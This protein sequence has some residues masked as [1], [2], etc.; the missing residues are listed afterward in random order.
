ATAR[1]DRTP[2][3]GSGRRT[4]PAPPAPGP[5]RARATRDRAPGCRLEAPRPG[6]AG[7]SLSPLRTN[8]AG[9]MGK[10]DRALSAPGP[11]SKPRSMH[12]PRG[13]CESD[14]ERAL[15]GLAQSRVG[16][17]GRVH[18]GRDRQADPERGALAGPAVHAHV[19]AVQLGDA[20]HEMEPDPQAAARLA[21]LGHDL[22]EQLEDV[23]GGVG[24]D[25]GTLVVDLDAHAG[26]VLLRAQAYGRTARAELDRVHEQV[27]QHLADLHLV[28]R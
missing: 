27:H 15:G 11:G 9:V 2:S 14:L 4:G 25:P 24:L 3:P 8:P 1:R 20:L 23:R 22:P 6:P 16:A 17:L 18:L 26:A 10:R 7:D 28:D 12:G 5:A 13:G 21:V 19:A